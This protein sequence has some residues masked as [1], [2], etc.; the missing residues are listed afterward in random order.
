MQK[1]INSQEAPPK[2][3]HVRAIVLETYQQQSTVFMYSALRELQVLTNQVACWKY[4]IVMHKIM[5]SGYR[6]V[7]FCNNMIYFSG[8][9]I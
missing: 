1:C 7:V 3:K 6:E 2:P 4:L 5:R 8:H 9:S